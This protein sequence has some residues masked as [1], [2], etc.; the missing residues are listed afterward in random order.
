MDKVKKGVEHFYLSSG[1]N[2]N[3]SNFRETIPL[4]K[5]KFR[6]FLGNSMLPH[7]EKEKNIAGAPLRA[8]LPIRVAE[9]AV[10]DPL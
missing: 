7:P 10:P 3:I 1:T 2:K 8:V 4:N 9:P 5:I 6:T